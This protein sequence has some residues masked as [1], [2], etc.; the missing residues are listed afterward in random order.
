[1]SLTQSLSIDQS[2]T[3]DLSQIR[4]DLEAAQA[5]FRRLVTSLSD[6]E[7]ERPCA[8]SK[9]TIKEVLTHLVL[10]VE[11]ANPMM[12]KQARKG[13]PMPKFLDTRLGHWLNYKMAVWA[14]RKVTCDSLI[15][16]YEAGIAQL[17]A[18]LNEV[19]SGE[20]TLPTAYPDGRPLT[21]ETVFHDPMAHLRL[22][23]DWIQQ[24]LDRS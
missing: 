17:Q 11:Q 21:I 15:G 9:W 12:L 2:F 5:E 6:A 7:L 22:H 24:S 3:P 1:M 18:A 14:A 4:A 13:K 16:R 19:Q 23:S 20:W 8:I 10:G